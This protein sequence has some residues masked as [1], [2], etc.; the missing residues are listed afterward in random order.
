MS[1]GR[2]ELDSSYLTVRHSVNDPPYD[3]WIYKVSCRVQHDTPV[4]K[5]WVVSDHDVAQDD[6]VVADIVVL[7]QLEKSLEA[8]PGAVVAGGHDDGC[9]GELGGKSNL[10]TGSAV[11]RY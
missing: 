5:L 6:I 10:S 4:S 3:Q 8:V 1:K 7:H 2:C 11:Y 9:K